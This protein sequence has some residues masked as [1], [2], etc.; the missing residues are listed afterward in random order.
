MVHATLF[1]P[2]RGQMLLE[3][4]FVSSP[5]VHVAPALFDWI[6]GHQLLAIVHETVFARRSICLA[7]GICVLT[8]L[9]QLSP[10]VSSNTGAGAARDPQDFPLLSL[11]SFEEHHSYHS[12]VKGAE[13][14]PKEG[15]FFPL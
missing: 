15:A 6:N 2:V 14:S 9:I 11:R 12:K 1:R 5:T 13:G 3:R 10:E 4:Q 8:A 7:I